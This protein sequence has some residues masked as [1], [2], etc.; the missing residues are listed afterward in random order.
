MRL[1]RPQPP[2]INNIN[3]THRAKE[4]ELGHIFVEIT[5]S[6]YEKEGEVCTLFLIYTCLALVHP[7]RVSLMSVVQQNRSKA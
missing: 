4:S 6:L 1:I 5:S 7:V 2:I 3:T